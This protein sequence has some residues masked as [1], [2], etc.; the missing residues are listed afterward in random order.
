MAFYIGQRL[1]FDDA[2]CT[3]RY[4][5]PLES[6]KGE[7][8]GVEWDLSWRGKHNGQHKGRQ[9]FQCLSTS[10]TAASF[11]RPSRRPDATWTLSEAIKNKYATSSTSD[12][13]DGQDH[14]L[15]EISGKTV[16]EVGFDKI[17]KQLSEL[18]ALKIVLVDAMNIVGISESTTSKVSAQQ[19]LAE[20]FPSITEL[21]LGRNLFETWQDIADAIVPFKE[22]RTLKTS[23]QRFRSLS[24]EMRPD[25]TSP[26]KFI[27][28]L[29]LNDCLLK[30]GQVSELLSSE[31][32]LLFP[33]LKTLWLSSNELSSFNI[34]T[35]TYYTSITNLVLENNAFPSLDC[36]STL[37]IV[38]PNVNHLSLQGNQ[39]K[40]IGNSIAGVTFPNIN[41]LN[42]GDNRVSSYSFVDALPTLFP[43]LNSLRISKNPLYGPPCTADAA[44][45]ASSDASYYLTL[46]RVSTLK[47]L[48]YTTITERD[49]EDG[50]IYY[51]SV[52]EKDIKK[53][54][55]SH[56]G[57]NEAAIVAAREKYSR[58]EIL[59]EKY[60][61]VNVLTAPASIAAV[62][63]MKKTFPP[64][65]LGAR[66]VNATFYIPRH[67]ALSSQRDSKTDLEDPNPSTSVT[68][69]T[70]LPPSI[71]VM[72][73][74]SLTSK[75]FQLAPLQF[76]LIYETE[77]FDPVLGIERTRKEYADIAERD[78]EWERWGDWDVDA[79][80][81]GDGNAT[82][83]PQARGEKTDEMRADE[84]E[85]LSE[86]GGTDHRHVFLRDG[87]L[88]HRREIEILDG[89][90]SWGDFLGGG[91]QIRVRIEPFA[92]LRQV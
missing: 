13:H 20:V 52:A 19:E 22:L 35:A 43:N 72:T 64:G 90:S 8:L 71:P 63:E 15:I 51:L 84:G 76:K 32:G 79:P 42:L 4:F 61:R 60:D 40:T 75:H 1:S 5:G 48:N 6:L 78:A 85:L 24:V 10:P 11:I 9:I 34:A 45:S 23:G 92:S 87:V 3:V 86:N 47:I 49:R 21:D 62:Q 69:T 33:A 28:E 80:G 7:W 55:Y 31:D 27:T 16:E 91:R 59:C 67:L 25:G 53:I 50:E 30:P 36:L 70:S 14:D 65:S 54:L 56:I 29:H 89:M 41:F 77:E 37:L 66:I 57:S 73:L 74:K 26:F 88:Y 17:Q 58:Y 82:E 12:G 68:W 81:E 39:I 18:S 46:S 2:L 38:F 83:Q 44:T